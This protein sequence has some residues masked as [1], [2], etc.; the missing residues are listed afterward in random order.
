MSG[1]GSL[2]WR[3][4]LMLLL[5]T[6]LGADAA[7]VAAPAPRAWLHQFGAA[8]RVLEVDGHRAF[9]LRPP[10]DRVA[11]GKPWVWYAPT[12]WE[13]NPASEM[14]W[15]FTRLL[16]RGFHIAGVDVGESYGSPAGVAIYAAFRDR[17][18]R[19]YGLAPRACLLAQSRGGLMLYNWAAEH[20]DQVACVAGVYPV[21][22]LSSYPGLA[23]AAPA[24]GMTPEELAAH[25][26][27]HNPVDRLAPLAAAGVP[28]WHIHGDSDAVVPLEANSAE[29]ARRYRALGGSVEVVVVPGKGHEAA[30]AFS[31]NPRLIEFLTQHG[32]PVATGVGGDAEGGD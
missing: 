20:P 12:F 11:P 29:L 14:G 30:A 21:C 8:T 5:L 26:A 3:G 18:V 31:E 19:E 22:D 28:I 7:E 6:A 10:L 17:L 13:S 27:E 9:L 25:L 15:Y 23:T 24:Y 16:A 4:C 1:Y 2:G 32:L